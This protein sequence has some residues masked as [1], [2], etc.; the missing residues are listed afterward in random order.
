VAGEDGVGKGFLISDLAAR[1]TRGAEM[2][3]GSEGPAP[4]SVLLVSQEDDPA[5]SMAYRLRA[6]GAVLSKVHDFSGP[7]F[8]VP[9]SLSALREE[10]EELGDV[11]LVVMDPLAAVSSIP[12]T[13]GNVRIR[14]QLVNPLERLAKETGVSLVAIHHTVKSGRLAGAKAITDTARQVL[15]VSRSADER[16]RLVAVEKS[17]LANDDPAEVAYTVAGTWPDVRCLWVNHKVDAERTTREQILAVLE[18]AG[19]PLDVQEIARRSGVP[20]QNVRTALSRMKDKREAMS[21]KRGQWTLVRPE[22]LAS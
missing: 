6:A 8:R 19:G 14:H 10:I 11:R 12:I 18:D 1:I 21:P 13:S 5:M 3:D 15:R 2:P 7:D 20:Y 16:I 4:G 17:N 9:D 22:D